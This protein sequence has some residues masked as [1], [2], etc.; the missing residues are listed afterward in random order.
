MP[1]NVAYSNYSQKKK[2]NVNTFH[3]RS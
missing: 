3:W 1:K 2:L